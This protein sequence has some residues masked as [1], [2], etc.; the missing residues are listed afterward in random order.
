MNNDINNMKFIPYH[1]FLSISKIEIP[2]AFANLISPGSKI[3]LTGYSS[4]EAYNFLCDKKC[5]SDELDRRYLIYDNINYILRGIE[6]KEF[7]DFSFS[8]E[9]RRILSLVPYRNVKEKKV[10]E[11]EVV[12]SWREADSRGC[13]KRYF[14][15]EDWL[16]LVLNESDND[17]FDVS[18]QFDYNDYVLSQ[19]KNF[20]LQ[21]YMS[22]M[23][24]NNYTLPI[25]DQDYS[26]PLNFVDYFFRQLGQYIDI[27]QKNKS[28]RYYIVGDGPG[29]ASAACIMLGVD[30]VSIEPNDIGKIARDIGIITSDEL[31]EKRDD[32][33]VF[34]A[35]VGDYVDYKDYEYYDRVIVDYSG[36]EALDLK[37]SY[38]GRG[39][40]YSTFD[41]RLST[42]PRR[43]NCLGL[44]K[45][46][47][48]YPMTPLAKQMCIENDIDIT[49]NRE[50]G[51]CV[52]TN[53]EEDAMNMISMELPSDMRARKGHVKMIKGVFFE[54]Y[55]EGQRVYGT[56]MIC[57]YHPKSYSVV[58][59]VNKYYIDGDII[60][61]CSPRPEKVRGIIMDDGRVMKLFYLSSYDSDGKHYGRYRSTELMFHN[62]I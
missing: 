28:R 13:L 53:R 27:I 33:I 38:G 45:D 23:R 54:Y 46:K 58:K 16:K 19:T 4:K 52:T 48:V 61:V 22:W 7:F 26:N 37:R 41:I 43:S 60:H 11:K 31:L 14:G 10:E 40:V 59:Y 5:D 15:K 39:S 1:Q 20:V 6:K 51:Y 30:Y 35:N 50:N 3:Y 34:L 62:E 44:L 57:E 8:I 9:K 29:T 55:D 2:I 47:R 32:D 24:L 18:Y 49:T 36:V 21:R 25:A 56:D 17:K 42:F 12:K